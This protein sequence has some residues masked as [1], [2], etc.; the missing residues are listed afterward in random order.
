MIF[1]GE[2]GGIDTFSDSKSVSV[3]AL[4]SGI[5]AVIIDIALV[6]RCSGPFLNRDLFYE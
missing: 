2:S 5:G 4:V 6:D 3:A 1:L